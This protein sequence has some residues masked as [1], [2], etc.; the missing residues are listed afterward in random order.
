MIRLLSMADKA[1][2][3]K[4]R[5]VD[6]SEQVM[7]HMV[8]I[9][10]ST[11]EDSYNHWRQEIYSFLS[12]VPKIKSGKR[13]PSFKFIYD[14]I[15]EVWGDSF[16]TFIRQAYGEYGD[17]T[18]AV[19]VADITKRAERYFRWLSEELSAKGAVTPSSVYSKLG[20]LG[21]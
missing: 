19:D 4:R 17:E 2:C 14:A 20:E 13:Y 15:W 7:W 11:H 1:Y 12:R 9:A 18:R 5:L 21:F 3:I 16:D 6:N 10:V 8:K